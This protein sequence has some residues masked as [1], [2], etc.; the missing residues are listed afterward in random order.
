MRITGLSASCS[1]AMLVAGCTPVV[2]VHPL[3]TQDELQKPPYLD[4]RLEGDWISAIMNDSDQD[5]AKP[6]PPCRVNIRKTSGREFP[7]TIESTCP[8]S[9]KDSDEEYSKYEFRFVPL[10]DGTFFDARFAEYKKKDQHFS[11]GDVA[12]EG[13][14]P[15]HLLGQ[16][17]VQK[18]FVR[19][20]PLQDDWVEKNWPEGSWV[21]SSV[22]KL[23]DMKI[24]I[25]PTQ[26]IRDLLSRNAGSPEAFSF[27]FFLCRDGTDCDASAVADQLTRTPD[28]KDV[29]AWAAAF[30]AKRGDFASAIALERH[31]VELDSDEDKDQ[32]ELGRLLLLSRDFDGARKAFAAAKEPSKT[33]SIKELVVRSYFLQGDYA[34]TVQA[35]RSMANPANLAS[36]DP[37]IL[38]Y[39]ALCRMGRA[40]DAESYL[41]QQTASFVGPGQEQLY[42][43]DVADRVTNGLETAGDKNRWTY[44]YALNALKNGNLD[45]GRSHLE[46]LAKMR[47]KNDLIGLAARVELDRLASPATG[48][49]RR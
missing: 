16:A 13:V 20:A 30:Y 9:D 40:K 26:E 41:H 34:G 2:S 8:P 12:D 42:L 29:L 17:W 7:Y 19:Y 23:K 32:F 4:Q 5:D 22:G 1:L 11:L 38:S 14:A 31:K 46:D 39:F 36:A 47:P 21:S 43:L 15:A 49:S 37:I 28:D 25:S 45:Q 44:Y 3:Y 35:A 6:Q 27:P 18:D 48:A 24:V 33:P 10:R